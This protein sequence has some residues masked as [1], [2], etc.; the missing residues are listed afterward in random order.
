MKTISSVREVLRGIPESLYEFDPDWSN[1]GNEPGLQTLWNSSGSDPQEAL[2]AGSPSNTDD[3]LEAETGVS[4]IEEIFELGADIDQ[5]QCQ[6]VMGGPKG[7]EI[8]TSVQHRGVE[9]LAWYMTFHVKGVQWGIHIPMSS[10]VYLAIDTFGSLTTD[11]LT[12]LRIAFRALHQHELFHFAVDYMSAQWEAITS[13]PCHRPARGLKDPG[14]GYILLEEELANAH[15][16]RALWKGDSALMVKGRTRALRSFVRQQPVGYRDANR[17][18]ASLAFLAACERLARDYIRCI[19]SYDSRH[20]SAVD[21]TALYP[22]VPMVD[23]RY[24]PLHVIHDEAGLGLPRIEIDLF[25][26]VTDIRE[27][28]AFEAQLACLPLSIR[29]AW[30]KVKDQLALT[31]ALSGLDFKFWERKG[32]ARVYSVRL[33]RGHRAHLSYGGPDAGWVTIGIGTHQDMGHG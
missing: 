2:D 11:W 15:M 33:S 25:R 22:L 24:C 30:Q 28:E 1:R 23:W 17:S 8:R 14:A 12:K 3:E 31:T 5:G 32:S 21:L 9:A 26:I 16:I 6:E 10:I 18:T 20:L 13:R 7:G 4:P 19:P 29:T 27:T